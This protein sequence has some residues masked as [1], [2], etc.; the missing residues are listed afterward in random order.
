MN[1]KE[2]IILLFGLFLVVPSVAY[3]QTGDAREVAD[4]LAK[5]SVRTIY[6]NLKAN[7]IPWKTIRDE[8]MPKILT[9]SLRSIQRSYSSDVILNDFLPTLIHSYYDEIDRINQEN[10]VSCMEESFIVSTIVPFIHECE[11]QLGSW[12][13]TITQIVDMVLNISYPYQ[14]CSIDCKSKVRGS[15]ST[16]FSYNFPVSKFSKICAE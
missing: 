7:G 1:K 15:F 9:R 13:I 4:K 14:V 10:S 2:L 3:S 5:A 12:N 11:V 16:A 8:H 6:K